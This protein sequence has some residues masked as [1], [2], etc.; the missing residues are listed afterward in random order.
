MYFGT[1]RCRSAMNPESRQTTHPLAPV[2]QWWRLV[3]LYRVY[4]VVQM[5]WLQSGHC[6]RNPGTVGCSA[7]CVM[8][9]WVGG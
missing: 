1:E 9:W 8:V 6:L 5:G 7:F 3:L 2:G 4:W